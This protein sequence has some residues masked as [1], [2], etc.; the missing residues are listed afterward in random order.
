MRHDIRDGSR[1]QRFSGKDSPEHTIPLG[2][3]ADQ[4]PLIKNHE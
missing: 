1:L 3:D 2:D 4:P